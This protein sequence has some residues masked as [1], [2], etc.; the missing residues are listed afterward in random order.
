MKA[1]SKVVTFH[2][3]KDLCI[4]NRNSGDDT[5]NPVKCASVC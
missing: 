2:K 5:H 4:L 1:L 3:Y